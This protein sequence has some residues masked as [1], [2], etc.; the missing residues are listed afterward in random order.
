MKTK[1]L[2]RWASFFIAGG[3]TLIDASVVEPN[4]LKIGRKKVPARQDAERLAGLRLAHLSDLH[5]GGLGWRSSTISAA[6]DVCNKEDVD[7]IAITGDFITGGGSVRMALD[8]LAALRKDIPRLAVLGNH[9]HVYGMRPLE[10]LVDGL[11]DLGII[12]LRNEAIHLQMRF[13]PVWFVGIDD[14]YSM[15]DDLVQAQAS[16]RDEC[17]PRILLTHYPDVVDRIPPNKY[18][19]ILAGHSHGG[20]VRLPILDNSV[21]NGHARTNYKK[22][23]YQV[24]G[25]ILHVSPGLGMSS[26]PLRFLNRPEVTILTFVSSADIC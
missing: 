25:N 14:C 6:L 3:V 24:N 23:I 7:L 13:G 4:W 18:R 1:T 5:I 20:Q 26:L 11:R 15:R 12:V 16:L 10:M 2:L 9:D 8:L 22:G 17:R 19:L 21:C